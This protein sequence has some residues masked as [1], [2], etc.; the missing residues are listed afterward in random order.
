VLTTSVNAQAARPTDLARS[1]DFRL[2]NRI[3]ITFREE[4]TNAFN[5]VSLGHPGAVVSRCG[6]D[7]GDFWCDSHRQPDAR[8]SRG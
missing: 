3:R 8:G 5:M 7:L 4:A 2:Q 6:L 1:R